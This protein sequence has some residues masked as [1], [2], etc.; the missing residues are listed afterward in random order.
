[1]L[2]RSVFRSILVRRLNI[3]FAWWLC[4]AH[5]TMGYY[6]CPFLHLHLIK[7]CCLFL[8]IFPARISSPHLHTA[9]LINNILTAGVLRRPV[10]EHNDINSSSRTMAS[11]RALDTTPQLTNNGE[12]ININSLFYGTWFQRVNTSLSFDVLK[13]KGALSF[14]IVRNWCEGG[15]LW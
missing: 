5:N 10:R 1:M 14:R 11:R 2:Q 8:F 12:A 15:Q 7:W 13:N 3:T 4:N 6:L 9:M